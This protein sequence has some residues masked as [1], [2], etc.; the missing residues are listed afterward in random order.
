MYGLWQ[1]GELFW[2][3]QQPWAVSESLSKLEHWACLP[4]CWPQCLTSRGTGRRREWLTNRSGLRY[5]FYSS[6]RR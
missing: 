1:S 6:R 3:G 2:K 5:R 4:T